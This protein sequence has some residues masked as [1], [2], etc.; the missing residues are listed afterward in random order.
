M[1]QKQNISHIE[2]FVSFVQKPMVV[3][4]FAFA[5]ALFVL[6]S[7][8]SPTV[9]VSSLKDTN[10]LNQEISDLSINIHL[11]ELSYQ[12]NADSM[13]MAAITEIKDTKVSHLNQKTLNSES[14]NL[15]I[16]NNNTED[17]NKL[18]DTVIF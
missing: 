2:M 5:L 4:S 10:T 15:N 1:S 9:S 12:Q 8:L 3:G 14:Q 18:L 17:I 6:I 7:V 11:K 13:I 16:E